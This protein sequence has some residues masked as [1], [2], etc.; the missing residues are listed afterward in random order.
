MKKKKGPP[1]GKRG[2]AKS[3]GKKTAA[4]SRTSG[5][6]KPPRQ[7]AAG[8]DRSD[9]AL[10]KGADQDQ[11]FFRDAVLGRFHDITGQKKTEEWLD[12]LK[13]SIDAFAEGAY[14]TDRDGRFLY[15]NAAGCRAL[16]YSRDELLK[17]RVWDINPRA[18]PERWEQVWQ[19]LPE[20]KFFTCESV[21]HRK[22]GTEFPVEIASTYVK[23]GEK[24]F[25]NG[26]ARDISDRKKAEKE[27]WVSETNFRDFVF[28][29]PDPIEVLALDGTILMCNESSAATY[30]STAAERIGRNAFDGIPPELAAERRGLLDRVKTTKQRLWI[31]ERVQGR[32]YETMLSPILDHSGEVV[33]VA[34][35]PHDVTERKQAEDALMESEEKFSKSFQKAPLLITL[36]EI[37]TGRLLEVNEKFLA[38][39]GF[40]R[41]EVIGRTVVEIGWNSEEQRSRLRQRFLE[42][43][44]VAGME[45]ALRRK[46]GREINCLY[47]GEA[48]TVGG[49]PCLLSIAQD[50][51]ERKR[52]EEEIREKEGRYR[53]LFEAANDGIFIQDATAFRD[54]NQRGADMYGL[55]KE[56]IIGRSP[57]EFSPE[58]QPDGRLSSEVAAEKIQAALNG[59]PQLFEWQ[60]L[61]ADGTPFDVEITLSRLELGGKVCLQAIVRDITERKLAAEA[62]HESERSLKTLMSN[63]PG[64]AYRC[65]NDRNWTMEYAS[66][67]AAGLTGYTPADLI[68]NAKI[69]YNDLI[70]PDDQES[71]WEAVQKA[72]GSRDKYTLNYRIRRADG[73]ERWV[74]EQ[75]QGVFSTTG[76]LLALEGFITDVSERC[77]LEE[78][79]LKTQKLE[80]IGTLAGGIAHD[81]NNL[82]QGIFGYISMARMTYDQKEKSLAML[83][84]AEKALH[85]SVSLTT[86]LLT[87]SKG[88][89]PAKKPMSLAPVIENSVKFAL[90]GSRTEYQLTIDQGLW[91]VNGDAGQ[92]GQVIQNIVLNADQAM[93]LGG[94]VKIAA[95]N[96]A[97]NDA[98]LPSTLAQGNYVILTIEDNGVGIPEKYLNKIF[99]PYFTTKEKGSG[100]GLATS[101]SI[102][103]NHEGQLLVTSEAGKGS[104]FSLFIPALTTRSTAETI[105]RMTPAAA[106]KARILVMDDEEIIRSF[107]TEILR[108]LGHEVEVAAHGEAAL[109]AYKEAAATGRPFDIV[110]LDLTVRGGMGGAETVQR[111]REIDPQVK[112]VVS[113]GYSD[114]AV[115]ADHLKH[116]FKAFLKKPYDVDE[117]R[118]VLNLLLS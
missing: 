56:E 5:P 22:D 86:Q 54:C 84:Q 12:L 49:K 102:I 70:R 29:Q 63:L 118:N 105:G 83:E 62:L 47:N 52:A 110:I 10:C 48:I 21:H 58:R 53:L 114:D 117:L 76:A 60:P 20:K 89:K 93:P 88:G 106:P 34:V 51:T 2:K 4:R 31:N 13:Q 57:A 75:G 25:F 99:D 9:A 112:A 71:V 100:L 8:L 32:F 109:A 82:L 108:E 30:D 107:A 50:I 96:I 73:Q 98:S 78:E 74:W 66:E 35:F 65:R 101:Y 111:L 113:S 95:R 87:F 80:S 68:G 90:S 17:L 79:R 92:L 104:L 91:Q 43:G 11:N 37:E 15:V 72:V 14:W 42:H 44:R 24:E 40:T 64:M 55:P 61:R 94:A 23:L 41:D 45:L 36:S 27:V 103:R 59:V 26:F 81:F 28:A 7:K 39:S 1:E 3:A 6:G 116:G 67:G 97:A 69:A 16:G 38:V 115:I 46:D 33:K 77:L 19:T 85:Q 18:T